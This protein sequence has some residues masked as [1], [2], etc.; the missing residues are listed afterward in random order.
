MKRFSLNEITIKLLER[1]LKDVAQRRVV[2]VIFL[3]RFLWTLNRNR[4]T[5]PEKSSQL[6]CITLSTPMFTPKELPLHVFSVSLNAK[7]NTFP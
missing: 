3:L 1:H 4:K 6:H 2:K 5:H 7:E